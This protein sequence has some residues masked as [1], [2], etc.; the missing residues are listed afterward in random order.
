MQ[1]QAICLF[2]YDR[3]FGHWSFKS[4][5]KNL[6][7]FSCKS[8]CSKMQLICQQCNVI[9]L[10]QAPACASLLTTVKSLHQLCQGAVPVHSMLL[11]P[12]GCWLL[13]R[14]HACCREEGTGRHSF[15]PA[16]SH[17]GGERSVLF[18]GHLT[19]WR[20]SQPSCFHVIGRFLEVYWE[21]HLAS[22]SLNRD[23][24]VPW[25]LREIYA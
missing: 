3:I 20:L 15:L 19:G 4:P 11:L 7:T 24:E 10:L 21:V 25:D 12:L 17:R 23:S 9:Y 8:S 13:P 16:A 2:L 18:P 5:E 14:L 22:P 6:L 1:S